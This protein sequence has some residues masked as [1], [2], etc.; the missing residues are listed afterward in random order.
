MTTNNQDNRSE[1][2]AKVFQNEVLVFDGAMGTELYRNHIFTNQCYDE[3]NIKNP[4]LVRKIHQSYYDVGVDVLTT[5]TYGASTSALDKYGLADKTALFNKAGAQLARAV[6]DQD[7]TRRVFVAGSIG[8]H[9]LSASF[10]YTEEELQEMARVQIQALIDGGVDFIEFETL[11]SREAMEMGAKLMLPFKDFPYVLSVAITLLNDQE[12][13]EKL[14]QVLAPMPQEYPQPIAFGLNC[15]QGP[16]GLLAIVEK[17]VKFI[18][19]PLIVQPNAGLPKIFEGRHIYYCTPEYMATYAM[20]YVKLGVSAVGGCCGTT[21]DQIAEV[22]KMVKPLAKGW[23][24]TSILKEEQRECHEVPDSPLAERSL[25]AAKLVAGQWITSVELTPPLGYNLET[26]LAKTKTLKEHGVDTIN[27]PDGPRASAR[28]TSLVVAEQILHNVGIEPILHFCCRD[29]NLIGM[30]ADLFGCAAYGIRNILFI[31]GD[32][33]K[34]G[35]YPSATGVFDTDSI[36]MCSVQTRL[37]RGVDLG[38]IAFTPP[39]NAVIGV[40]VDPNALDQKMEMSRLRR[41]IEA[42]AHFI[43]TQPV[44]D[45]DKLLSFFDEY[46]DCKIPVIAGIWPLT[47]F[48][49]AIF[50][51]NEVPGVVVPDAI[52]ER[53]EKV[54]KEP[55]EEQTKVGVEIARESIQRICDRVAGIEVSAPFGRI[56]LALDVI[57][58]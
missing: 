2:F 31:T 26:I 36:G 32:P 57:A 21:P 20:D 19:R 30:Q 1:N 51:K 14:D 53:M 49:N 58:L 12:R 24:K 44:F 9:Y 16:E 28:I 4:A 27:L 39:T 35:N 52:M 8:P 22:V 40:G 48:S 5:N 3:L 37:N 42:G 45:P 43:I 38:G 25:L 29:R 33:P 54:S 50:M 13:C 41:K 34:A 7:P 18:D 23:R 47:S 15:G 56:E 46:G 17:A 11:P 55:R 10:R 6:A